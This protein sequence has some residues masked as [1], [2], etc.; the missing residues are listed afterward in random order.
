MLHNLNVLPL[1]LNSE[2]KTKCLLSLALLCLMLQAT[3]AE[4]VEIESAKSAVANMGVGW[5]LG[6][7]LD[8]NNQQTTGLATENCWGQPTT[9]EALLR[10]IK[11]GGFSTVR[12]PVT[13]F[14]HIDSEGNIDPVWLNRVKEVVDYCIGNGLYCILNVHHD[15]GADAADGSFVSWIKADRDVY[16]QTK[17]R[18]ENLWR[19]IATKFKDYDGHLLFEAYNEMLDTKNSWCFASFN[20]TGQYDAALA[21]SAYDGLNAY[22]QSFVTVVRGT[23]GNNLS[24][25]L[26]V[27]TYAAAPGTGSWNSHLQEPVTRMLLPQD[28]ATGHLIFEVHSYPGIENLA[29]AKSEIDALANTLSNSLAKKGAP[30]IVGEWGTNNGSSDYIN[31][32]ADMLVFADYFVKTMKKANIATI[33][34]MGISDGWARSL[35]LFSEADLAQTI[36]KAWHG[37]G[38]QAAWPSLD[39]TDVDFLLKYNSQWGEINL[40]SAAIT[41]ANYVSLC[42]TLKEAPKSGSLQV[43]VYTKNGEYY[44]PVTAMQTTVT[45]KT[46]ATYADIERI[47]LQGTSQGIENAIK[48]IMLVKKGGGEMR[49]TPTVFWGSEI[50]PQVAATGISRPDADRGL[51]SQKSLFDLSGRK[52]QSV[53]SGIYIQGGRK[54]LKR[55]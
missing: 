28:S 47:T 52:C 45:F 21:S 9:T 26:V 40:V 2:M 12:V 53:T 27:N 51:T 54:Y 32:R 35:P 29:A 30:V 24:R 42:L 46:D 7:T 6:N 44:Q 16:A 19:Q 4:A 18:Y 15:T 14:S 11:D 20:A 43:K 10:M 37:D 36:V 48:Q 50:T 8:A 3:T 17:A 23:G 13:W 39:N 49:L 25:N 55:K 31:R 5:N 33:Y 1:L 41:T 34:W 38:Y 22:A